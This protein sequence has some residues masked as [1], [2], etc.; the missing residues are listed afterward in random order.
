MANLIIRNVG[1]ITKAQLD[2]NKVNVFMGPQ[3]SGKS[4][5]A[6]IISQCCWYE[7]SFLLTGEDYDFYRGLLDFHRMDEGYFSD[8]SEIIYVSQWITINC[9]GKKLKTTIKKKKIGG[10]I[11]KNLKIEY[12]PAERNFAAAI[13]NLQKYNEIYDNIVN[14]LFDWMDFKELMT[15]TKNYN[16]P[17]ESLKIEYKYDS[18]TKED[19]LILPNKKKISLQRSSSGQQSLTPLLVVCEYLFSELYNQKRNPSPV[20]SKHIRELLPDSM[21]IEYNWV[22]ETQNF[23]QNTNKQESERL[24]EETKRKIWEKIGFSTDY[25]FSNVIIEEPEQNL[26]PETQKE[27]I[28]HLMNKV[29]NGDHKLTITTHS[30]YI[31]YA[32]NNCMMGYLVNENMPEDEKNELLSKNSW[33]DP[34]LVSVW[35]IKEIEGIKENEENIRLVK[36]T[37]TGTISKHYFNRI[38]N[39][40]ME[41]YYDMLTYLNSNKNEA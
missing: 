26:F 16:S 33:I 18:K 4:T 12:I 30:P 7:K 38:M 20:E 40:V 32:L 14:F 6:K 17:L 5:I 15:K 25:A 21:K 35:E 24:I 28:Y 9:K 22:V 1:P 3:S 31:L 2:L 27:L 19:V 23:Q 10:E 41:E 8:N 36:N 11:Y 37:D 29:V 34:K 13:P 39:D